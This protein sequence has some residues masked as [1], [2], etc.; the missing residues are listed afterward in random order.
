VPDVLQVTARTKDDEIM[1]LRHVLH[2]TFGVQ[3]HPES[4]LTGEGKKLLGNFLS[5]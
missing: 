1:G 3:F 2:P 5:M 4:I